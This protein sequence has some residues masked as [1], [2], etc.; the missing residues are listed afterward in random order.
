MRKSGSD[1]WSDETTRD[2]EKEKEPSIYRG[3][4]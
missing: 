3:K 1:G 2:S 4:E